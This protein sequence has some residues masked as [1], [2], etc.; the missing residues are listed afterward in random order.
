ME[1]K[2]GVDLEKNL[3]GDRRQSSISA[4]KAV[5]VI[6]D[7]KGGGNIQMQYENSCY[8]RNDKRLRLITNEDR[9]SHDEVTLRCQ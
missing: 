1:I 8:P 3:W 7:I 5:M 4:I 2:V 9:C 6:N